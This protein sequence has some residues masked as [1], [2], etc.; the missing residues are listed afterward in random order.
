MVMKLNECLENPKQFGGI[1]Q[2]HPTLVVSNF[3]TYNYKQFLATK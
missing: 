1:L 2:T 3:L